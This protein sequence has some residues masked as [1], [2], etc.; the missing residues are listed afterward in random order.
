MNISSGVLASQGFLQKITPFSKAL[1]N[2]EFTPLTNSNLSIC[3]PH[4]LNAVINSS[5]TQAC[6]R[7]SFNQQ[8][9]K[10]KKDKL[11]SLSFIVST[12]RAR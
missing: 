12:N 6:E 9:L 7:H 5:E 11:A 8:L 1:L 4:Y 2:T 10:K 3:F